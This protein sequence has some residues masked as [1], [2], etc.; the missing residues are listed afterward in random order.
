MAMM[1]PP[2][3]QQVM[4]DALTLFMQPSSRDSANDGATHVHAP[5]LP[6]GYAPIGSPQPLSGDREGYWIVYAHNAAYDVSGMLIYDETAAACFLTSQE[7]MYA[8]FALLD[9]IIDLTLDS[10]IEFTDD[11]NQDI[12]PLWN[13]WSRLHY[14]YIQP[15]QAPTLCVWCWYEEHP[16]TPFPPAASSKCCALHK[17]LVVKGGAA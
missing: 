3:K 10:P 17:P 14:Q 8:L 11:H 4:A 5:G 7:A 13:T 9:H 12:I 15:S 1:L 16:T 6:A 2:H